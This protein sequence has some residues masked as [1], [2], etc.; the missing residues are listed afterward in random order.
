MALGILEKKTKEKGKNGVKT[1]GM[2][3]VGILL[4]LSSRHHLELLDSE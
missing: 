1:N 4:S 3:G 2:A